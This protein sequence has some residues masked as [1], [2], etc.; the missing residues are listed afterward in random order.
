MYQGIKHAKVIVAGAGQSIKLYKSQILSLKERQGFKVIGINNMTSLCYPD[1]H[2]WT[3]KKR[4]LQ[5]GSCINP[6]KSVIMFGGK[7]PKKIIRR[8]CKGKYLVVKYTDSE[9]YSK[10]ILNEDHIKGRFRTA[11][12]LAI[13]VATLMEAQDIIVVGMDG[14]TY[15]NQMQLKT[16]EGSQHCYGAGYT[17]DASWKDCVRKDSLVSD[18]LDDLSKVSSFRIATPSKFVRHYD[19]DIFN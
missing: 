3:N 11:G 9:R 7:M 12:C 10:V 15:Y 2:L 6:K 13:A 4:Y 17:D 5:F 19:P 8:H 14:F 1:Y 16:E 18:A